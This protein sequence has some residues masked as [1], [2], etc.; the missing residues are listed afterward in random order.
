MTL[1]A[2][3]TSQWQRLSGMGLAHVALFCVALTWVLPFQVGMHFYPITTFYQEWG[4]AVLGLCGMLLLLTRRYWRGPSIPRIVLLP[5][6]FLLIL[7]LQ[8]ALGRV[9]YPGQAILFTLY[10][11]WTALMIMLGRRLREEFGMPLLVTV[12]AASL[13]FGAEVSAVIGLAQKYEWRNA[14]FDYWVIVKSDGPIYANMGQANHLADYLALGLFSLGLLHTRWKM[15]AWLA[16]FLAIPLLFALVLSASRSAWL[17]LLAMLLMA[18]LWQRRDKSNRP[19][20]YF[21]LAL[22]LGFGLMHFVAKIPWLAGSGAVTTSAE[23]MVEA[24]GIIGDGGRQA[25]TTV[26]GWWNNSQRLNVWYESW[27]IFGRFP[28]LGAGFGQFGWQHFQLVAPLHNTVSHDLYN[29][30]H[31]I[32]LETAAEMGLAGL[33]VLLGTLALWVRQANRAPRTPYHWWGAGVLA[34]LFIHSLL[35]YPLFYSY[36]LGVAAVTLGVMDHTAFRFRHGWAGHS[37]VVAI[38]LSGLFCMAQM[39]QGY[40]RLELAS[41]PIPAG[42]YEYERRLNFERL[43]LIRGAQA[44]LLQPFIELAM[45]DSGWNHVR[46]KGELNERA[47]HFSPATKVVYRQAIVLARQ[48]RQAEAEVQLERAIWAY[49]EDFSENLEKLQKLAQADD[50]PARF[51]AL[52][53]FAVQKYAERQRIV[54]GH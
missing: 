17:F 35:E 38:W 9:E 16:A 15:R 8:F 32:V 3:I 12:L 42:D 14:V 48:G 19:L 34:V 27:L 18:F 39:W 4:T 2:S 51:P 5:M 21:S 49:P 47:M 22:V 26:G 46:D 50:N 37:L 33:A 6:G 7:W 1:P 11:L 13:L 29:H 40:Q 31:N 23:R 24:A 45:A 52:A 53:G 30:A 44:L 28:V 20:L 54:G 43:R 41:A 25:A 10:L 36:F